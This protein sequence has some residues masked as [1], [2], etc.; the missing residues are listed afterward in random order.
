MDNNN[1]VKDEAGSRP[2]LRSTKTPSQPQL[3]PKNKNNTKLS[4]NNPRNKMY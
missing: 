2:A 1:N 3:S 4:E